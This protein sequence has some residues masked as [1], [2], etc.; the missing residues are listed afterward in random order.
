MP[1]AM[2]QIRAQLGKDAVILQ[3][4]EI[5]TK[6]FFGL[7]KKPQV[8]VIAALDPYPIKRNRKTSEHRKKTAPQE[9]F[10]QTDLNDVKQQNIVSE[11]KHLRK[12]LELQDK[13]PREQFSKSYQ[14]LY[15]YLVSQE[16]KQSI[17]QDV[18]KEVQQTYEDPL[19]VSIE[20]IIN[21]IKTI[22]KNRLDHLSFS[23]IERSTRV[24]QL[25]GP[26]GVGKTTTL[27]K[28][29]AKSLLEDKKSIAFIT[30]DTYRIA[31]IEQLK[32]YA[33]ILEVPVEVAYS[34][35]DYKRAIEKLSTVDLIFVDTAGRNF[36]ESNYVDEL[37]KYIDATKFTEVF[38][39]AALTAK[40]ADI[41]YTLDKFSHIKNKKIIFTKTD[42]TRQYGSLLNIGS[43]K[44][45]DIAYLT[46]GQDVPHDIEIPSAKR[47]SQYI[48]SEYYE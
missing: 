32:T 4:K 35:E 13:T 14:M 39:V 19:T 44:G 41:S 33:R 21:D 15:D 48:M 46:N 11:I 37:T 5:K 23:G 22:I 25:I 3:S 34:L 18:I 17:A 7:F 47:I 36:R 1:E 29:A 2:K 6:G 12:I 16:V 27:A 10:E 26:T 38:F 31:A 40:Y 8:E 24:V 20:Q 43:R 9:L 30:M 28:L 45:I 42:E